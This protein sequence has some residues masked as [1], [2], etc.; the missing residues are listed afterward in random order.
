MWNIIHYVPIFYTEWSFFTIKN[1]VLVLGCLTNYLILYFVPRLGLS[2]SW[3]Y[4]DKTRCVTGCAICEK[5]YILGYKL[6]Y[7]IIV[8]QTK[9]K[10][11]SYIEDLRIITIL[12]NSI[13]LSKLFYLK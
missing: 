8:D 3:T 13:K 12:L 11:V 5:M 10:V 1:V 2:Y 9:T 4:L 7:W 6:I